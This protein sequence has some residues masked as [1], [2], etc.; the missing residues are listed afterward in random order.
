M[1]VQAARYQSCRVFHDASSAF[2]SH[3]VALQHDASSRAAR[4]F[5]ALKSLKLVRFQ[6]QQYAQSIYRIEKPPRKS[7]FR[8]KSE[9]FRFSL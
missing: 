5:Q 6:V 3:A 7:I 9:N 2:S 4:V 1:S 8:R